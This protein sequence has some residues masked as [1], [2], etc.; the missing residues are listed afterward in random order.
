MFSIFR[1]FPVNRFSTQPVTVDEIYKA[2]NIKSKRD[3]TDG[4][5]D[6]GNEIGMFN[7]LF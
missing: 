3:N 7:C 1:L 2:K 5:D 6:S 4:S